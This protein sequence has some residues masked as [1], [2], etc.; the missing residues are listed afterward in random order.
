M[1]EETTSAFATNAVLEPIPQSGDFIVRKVD[2]S[3]FALNWYEAMK[4][5]PANMH[6][7]TIREYANM[8][9][10]RGAN[11]ILEIS[12]VDPNNVPSGYILITA[13]NPNGIKDNFYYSY[14]GYQRPVG[15]PGSGQFLS[16]SSSD[17]F[18]ALVYI[19]TGSA[20]DIGEVFRENRGRA[21]SALCVRDSF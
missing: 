19:S 5:C 15:E 16:S 10:S 9:Q 2:G 14:K 7:P 20:G 11:G 17:E 6:L 1:D 4:A 21:N 13:T 12:Q 8:N 3:N 18:P